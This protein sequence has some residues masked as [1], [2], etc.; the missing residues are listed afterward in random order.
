MA[1]PKPINKCQGVGG[2]RGTLYFVG[3]RIISSSQN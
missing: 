2:I 1:T 3:K